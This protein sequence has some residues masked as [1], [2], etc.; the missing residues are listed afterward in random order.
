MPAGAAESGAELARS[1]R[2][3]QGQRYLARVAPVGGF[4]PGAHYTI[5]YMNNKERWRYPAQTD[6][7]IDA[8]PLQLDDASL[9]LALDGAPARQLLPLEPRSG[10]CSSQQPAVVQNFHYELPAAYQQYNPQSTTAPIWR[11]PRPALLRLALRRSRVWHHR[12]GR[13]ARSRLQHL[14]GRKGS[15]QHSGWAALLEVEDRVR[16]TNVLTSDLVRRKAAPVPP[17][18]S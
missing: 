4:K 3:G 9:Q 2:E 14:R 8:E 13:Y 1:W 5:R 17:S 18:A 10:M 16:P 7:F 11:R 15:R 12:T 6:F